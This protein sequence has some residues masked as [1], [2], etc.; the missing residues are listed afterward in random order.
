MKKLLPLLLLLS[1]CTK[2]DIVTV[3][4]RYSRNE[5]HGGVLSITGDNK[6]DDSSFVYFLSSDF[7]TNGY[8]SATIVSHLVH[9]NQVV[10]HGA[11]KDLAHYPYIKYDV[12][13][14]NGN[15]ITENPVSMIYANSDT[16]TVNNWYKRITSNGY[17]APT[18][19]EV[20]KAHFL[21]LKEIFPNL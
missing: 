4:E 1:S 3:S 6:Y 16:A 19:S 14:K 13:N 2:Q 12:P 15:V 21:E 17:G 11:S 10:N 8:D 18:H 9:V 5:I 7:K 20:D